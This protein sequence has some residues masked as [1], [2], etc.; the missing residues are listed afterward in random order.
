MCTIAFTEPVSI[1]FTVPL[2][3]FLALIFIKY[4]LIFELKRARIIT[5]NAS[6]EN[7]T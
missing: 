4:F 1:D 7:T 5:I 3:W 2:S 6:N